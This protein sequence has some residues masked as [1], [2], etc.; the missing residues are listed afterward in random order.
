MLGDD[1]K[2][3]DKIK[4]NALALESITNKAHPLYKYVG[5]VLTITKIMREK[6]Y[7][8]TY[9]NFIY[10]QYFDKYKRNTYIGVTCKSTN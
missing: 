10:K 6:I 8:K 4:F 9:H 2:V 5:K 7:F 3:G 1:I